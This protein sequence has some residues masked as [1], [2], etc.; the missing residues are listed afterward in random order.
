LRASAVCARR[1]L[2]EMSLMRSL[3]SIVV[4]VVLGLVAVCS[5]L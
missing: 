5:L 3:M 2:N 1:A 4:Q